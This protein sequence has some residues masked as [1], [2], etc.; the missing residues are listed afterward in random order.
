MVLFHQ[1]DKIASMKARSRY[2]WL[3]VF[4]AISVPLAIGAWT[5][6]VNFND[7]ND[8]ND[9]GAQ[10]ALI[11]LFLITCVYAASTGGW[12]EGKVRRAWRE[13]YP[14]RPNESGK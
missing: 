1:P 11:C 10:I 7:P 4:L 6:K 13:R 3:A 12:I 9:G 5:W 8:N 14:K 2:I